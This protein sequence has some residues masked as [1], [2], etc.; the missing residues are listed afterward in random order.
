M[1]E[2]KI[3]VDG[4]EI[5]L[6]QNGKSRNGTYLKF[7]EPEP[8]V[9]MGPGETPLIVTVYLRPGWKPSDDQ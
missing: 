7:K 8:Y 6:E 5:V 1:P 2:I 4:E 3:V 9:S